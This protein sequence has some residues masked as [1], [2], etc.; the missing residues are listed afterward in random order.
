MT[1]QMTNSKYQMWIS[2]WTNLP[3]Q[4]NKWCKIKWIYFTYEIRHV[5]SQISNFKC[6]ILNSPFSSGDQLIIKIQMLDFKFQI[7]DFEYQ[8][9]NHKFWMSNFKCQSQISN[10]EQRILPLR[11][12]RFTLAA[13]CLHNMWNENVHELLPD[14]VVI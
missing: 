14:N 11:K 2:I 4:L 6:Q 13:S 10:V 9:P 5:K 7:S 8:I 1:F 3:I 12:S